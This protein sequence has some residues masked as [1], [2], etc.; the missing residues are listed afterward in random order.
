MVGHR[1]WVLKDLAFIDIPI[2]LARCIKARTESVVSERSV[3]PARRPGINITR[4]RGEGCVVDVRVLLA[5]VR[6]SFDTVSSIGIQAE[7]HVPL[8]RHTND[9]HVRNIHLKNN[10]STSK[11]EDVLT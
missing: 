3:F 9:D 7:M 10:E 1:V 11:K 8:L 2:V 4:P 6:M 5:Y